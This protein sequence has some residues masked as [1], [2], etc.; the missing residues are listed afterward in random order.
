MGPL[1]STPCARA[2]A[3]RTGPH[4]PEPMAARPSSASPAH[5]GC[6][7]SAMSALPLIQAFVRTAGEAHR[8]PTFS[9][10]M[11]AALDDELSRNDQAPP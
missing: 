7:E 5:G 11:V 1:K 2:L 10:G 4:P 3:S 8:N 6:F 9:R